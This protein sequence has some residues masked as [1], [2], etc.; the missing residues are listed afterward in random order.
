M[1]LP[2]FK[3]FCRKDGKESAFSPPK[4]L[5]KK[6][7]K[8]KSL[9]EH[10][11][12]SSWASSHFDPDLSH[13]LYQKK[14]WNCEGIHFLPGDIQELMTTFYPWVVGTKWG[15]QSVYGGKDM[16]A[17]EFH[18]AVHFHLFTGDGLIMVDRVKDQFYP[19]LKVKSSF[20]ELLPQELI[21][22]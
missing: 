14:G 16:S 9:E 11:L 6:K 8:N 15:K 4:D 10:G 1:D 21:P 18:E 5:E 3:A 7:G 19:I 22:L 20:K 2:L 13:Y 17:H 12:A